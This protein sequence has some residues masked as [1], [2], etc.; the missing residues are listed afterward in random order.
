VLRSLLAIT[1][2][3]GSLSTAW[4]QGS[5]ADVLL[6]SVGDTEG[7]K[8][9]IKATQA[10]Q[11]ANP[12]ANMKID[13][14][15]L[16]VF[17]AEWRAQNNL[18]YEVQSWTLK[19]FQHKFE[20]AAHLWSAIAPKIPASFK[21]SSEIAQTY[22][23]WRLGL[24][25]TFFDRFLDQ[26]GEKRYSST[27]AFLALDQLIAPKTAQWI[28]D[29]AITITTS[30]KNVIQRLGES[31]EFAKLANAW[32]ALRNGPK[33]E[34]IVKKLPEGHP[35][36]IYLANSAVIYLSKLGKLAE[37]GR[38]LK[39]HVE[40]EIQRIGDPKLLAKHYLNLARLLYQAGAMDAAES[41]YQRIPNS[42]P[43]YLSA[44]TELTWVHLRKGDVGQLRGSLRTLSSSAFE[45]RFLPDVYLVRS[46]SNLKLC[47]YDKVAE[48][49]NA[50][51]KNNQLWAKR[52]TSSLTAETEAPKSTD[53]YLTLAE[54]AAKLREEEANKLAELAKKS[55]K[56]ALPAVGEQA[57]WKNA[58]NKM[59]RFSEEAKKTIA[60]EKRKIWKNREYV[61]SET[62]RK[63]RFVKVEA[64]SQMRMAS[65]AQG[66][67]KPVGDQVSTM[68]S[69]PIK[70]E[71]MVFK[72]DGVFWPDE[73][74]NLYSV[75]KNFCLS[76]QK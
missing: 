61:L 29:N 1:L 32:T 39:V 31:S 44:Q 7:Q 52:I 65:L 27:K 68:M 40:P 60:L 63:M 6:Q 4:A 43:E 66:N 17:F 37:A 28:L 53:F 49:F 34:V 64:M 75:A 20:E 36:K 26:A 55:I 56:A 25:Q 67:D 9:D 48:D 11:A 15:F 35:L 2:L 57:H 46:I 13:D 42:L 71:Q 30:H 23:Y 47:Q 12:F 24:A 33:A 41:F 8:L 59:I 38:I 74:F 58:A 19:I 45:D 3:L 22:L 69:A 62:I 21:A 70:E 76:K 50:F 73:L 18:P 10:A 54:K 72:F 5:G 16:M 51:I 14:G